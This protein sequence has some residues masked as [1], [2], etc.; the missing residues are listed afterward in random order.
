M[1]KITP[2][3]LQLFNQNVRYEDPLEI[4][5]FVLEFSESP[6]VTTSFGPYAAAVL[7][8]C[9]RVKKDIPVIWC[10]T[11]YNTAATYKHAS[12]LTETLQLHLDI[13]A[14]KFTTAFLNHTMGIP[15]LDNPK[16]A[17]FSEKVKLEPFERAFKKYQPDVWFTNVRKN[18]TTFREGLDV[19]SFSKDGILKVSP[20]YHFADDEL[21]R[22]IQSQ[23]LPLEFD[24][25][26]PVKASAHRECGIH[27]K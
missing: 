18:Q 24:Y 21:V 6:V 15:N 12:F 1:A 2:Q 22:Y 23:N 4:V 5:S 9:S 25:Y 14:P 20:F 13:F 10:D 27:F 11:G 8:A 17:L 7:Y 16:H 26:D 3:N 19:F